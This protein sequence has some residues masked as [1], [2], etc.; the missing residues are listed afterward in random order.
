VARLLKADATILDAVYV[1]FIAICLGS[2]GGFLIVQEWRACVPFF[3]LTAWTVESWISDRQVR[4]LRKQNG[5]LA[6]AIAMARRDQLVRMIPHKGGPC[7]ICK[8]SPNQS[9]E[10]THNQCLCLILSPN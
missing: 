2:A 9:T 7:W 6:K 3:I 10:D 4:M 1:V 8:K 5:A